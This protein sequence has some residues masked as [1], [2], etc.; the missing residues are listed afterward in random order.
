MK[1]I[2]VEI[3]ESMLTEVERATRALDMTREDFVRTA[4]ERAL[5]QRETIALERRH[6][7]GY[8]AR[9]QTPEEVGEWGAEQVWGEP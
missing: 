6:A 8:D 2:E 9:P 3:E 5:Q 4:L 1:S 7:R